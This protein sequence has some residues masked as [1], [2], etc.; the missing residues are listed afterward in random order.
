MDV[1]GLMGEYLN[2]EQ[3]R[4]LPSNFQFDD[5]KCHFSTFR[6]VVDFEN[7]DLKDIDGVNARDKKDRFRGLF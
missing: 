1:H 6:A 2:V 5:K 3:R 4:F 7:L